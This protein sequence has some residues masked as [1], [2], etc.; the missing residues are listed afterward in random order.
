MFMQVVSLLV[1][2]ILKGRGQSLLQFNIHSEAISK[3]ISIKAPAALGFM[4][5]H[6]LCKMLG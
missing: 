1:I 4:L 5:I 2:S 3:G 6:S